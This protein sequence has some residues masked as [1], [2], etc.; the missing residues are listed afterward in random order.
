[1]QKLLFISP[2]L[3]YPL[4]SGGKVKSHKLLSMLCE[5]YQVSLVCPLK[6]EDGEFVEEFSTTVSLANLVCEPI[7]IPRNGVNLLV[8]Y[9]KAKPLNLY[10]SFT[11]VLA[12]YIDKNHQQ[13]DVIFVDHYEAF[14][15]V[16]AS[17]QGRVIYHSHN[18]YF[19]MWQRYAQTSPNPLYRLVTG[20]EAKRV[21]NT[22][23]AI[24]KAADLVFAA[25]NDIDELTSLGA[26]PDKFK[27]TYHLG[28]DEQL[29]LPALEFDITEKRLVYVGFLGWE[30]NAA[31]LL[32]FLTESW[33]LIKAKEPDVEIDVIGKNPDERLQSIALHDDSIHLRG[34]VDDLED[35]FPKSRISIAPLQFGSGMKVKVLS[36]M[37]R[38]IPIVTTDVGAEGIA[39]ENGVHMLVDNEPNK[40]AD[41]V[42]RL[43]NDEPLWTTLRDKSRELIDQK[44]TWR[45]LFNSMYDAMEA[46]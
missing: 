41:D 13:F 15:Y 3:P 29:A 43:L 38:G 42:V 5:Q 26:E 21:L 20:F 25:P 11:S 35:Y 36:A 7:D 27:A 33:P 9:L 28:D 22:E 2:E 8:S 17:F 1:M 32:W 44:Y 10:R 30:P 31:G 24:C 40:I 37:A 14:Q 16:P 6:L 45:A 39:V 34:F 46:L 4:R 23:L 12:D 19:K 18:A